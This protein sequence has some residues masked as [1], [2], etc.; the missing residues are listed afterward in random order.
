MTRPNFKLC[1]YSANVFHPNTHTKREL[2][3]VNKVVD[4][5]SPRVMETT[6]T[7]LSEYLATFFI[8]HQHNRIF[9]WISP[10]I[11]RNWDRFSNRT[12]M[13]AMNKNIIWKMKPLPTKWKGCRNVSKIQRLIC[14]H[15][16]K[17]PWIM[18]RYVLHPNTTHPNTTHLL[19]GIA[20]RYTRVFVPIIDKQRR[21]DYEIAVDIPNDCWRSKFINECRINGAVLHE[22]W[23]WQ[24]HVTC[25]EWRFY[26]AGFFVFLFLFYLESVSAPSKIP[27]KD[28][29]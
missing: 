14:C 1:E 13:W 3:S 24:V 2:R 8:L 11:H 17:I 26:W 22:W 27:Q 16:L 9:S 21:I 23:K 6:L 4:P 5:C 25:D 19:I 12:L 18:N 29:S 15:R 28:H 10:G 20:R 7:Q